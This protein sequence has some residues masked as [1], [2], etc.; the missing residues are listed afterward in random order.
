MKAIIHAAEQGPR[1]LAPNHLLPKPM[2]PILNK[3]VLEFLVELLARHDFRQIVINSNFLTTAIEEYFRDGTRYGV[4]IAYAFDSPLVNGFFA[5]ESRGT[6]GALRGIHDHAGFLDETFVVMNGEVLL[7]FD[8]TEL[9]RVHRA[10]GAAVTLALGEVPY[11]QVSGHNVVVCDDAGRITEI[12]ERPPITSAR[13]NTV[14]TGVYLLEPEVLEHIPAD[15]PFDLLTQ[16]LPFLLAEKL[17]VFGLVQPV[18]WF[19]LGKLTDYYQ[20]VQQA[21]RGKINGFRLPGR[22]VLPGLF[23]GLNTR[24]DL[25]HTTIS[26]P[27]CIGGGVTI[28]PGCTLIGPSW[29]GPG[30]VIESGAH[31]EKSL[32]FDHTRVGFTANVRNQMLS[33]SYAVDSAGTVIDL[34]RSEMDW[35]VADA[36]QPRRELKLDHLLIQHEQLLREPWRAVLNALE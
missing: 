24:L 28:E 34:V 7:D 35:A 27:V 25:D 6:A 1:M 12:Q 18:Q 17:P 19:N 9:L 10:R 15:A 16:L 4:E 26:P 21:L 29:I 22:E 32:I 11:Y 3:P 8:L 14:S 13:R 36:R 30:C 23:V 20:V 5:G 2:I 33:G 31:I